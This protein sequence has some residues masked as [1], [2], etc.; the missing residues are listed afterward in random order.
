M[1]IDMKNYSFFN[2]TN[3]KT[4]KVKNSWKK[5][6]KSAF[7]DKNI[8]TITT[9]KTQTHP[10]TISYKETPLGKTQSP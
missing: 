2:I 9:L 1:I 4:M 7:T 6:T 10:H 5:K 3:N 8:F